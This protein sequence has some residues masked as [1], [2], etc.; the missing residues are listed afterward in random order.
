MRKT[1]VDGIEEEDD[2]LW[3]VDGTEHRLSSTFASR[4]NDNDAIGRRRWGALSVT[5]KLEPKIELDYGP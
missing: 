4:R 1:A 5:E 2:V 3:T